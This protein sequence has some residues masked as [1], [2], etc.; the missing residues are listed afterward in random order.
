MGGV[1]RLWCILAAVLLAILALAVADVDARV[2][3]RAFYD[4]LE[5]SP[6]ASQAEIKSA[7]KRLQLS[8]HPDRNPDADPDQIQKVNEAYTVLKDK[9]KRATYDQHGAEG[10]QREDAQEGGQG[11]F[12]PFNPFASFFGGGHQD[13][14]ENKVPSGN[15]VRMSLSVT[16]EQIY[17]GAAITVTRVKG[18]P[19]ETSGTRPCKCRQVRQRIQMAP[20]FFTE[21][22]R[23][24]CEQCPNIKFVPTASQL[25]IELA[26][27]HPEGKEITFFSEGDPHIDGINGDLF[28]RVE[29]VQHDLFT[30]RENDLHMNLTISVTDALVGFEKEFHHLD[31][32]TFKIRRT[33][34]TPPGFIQTIK[35][36]G[37]PVYDI[38][39]MYG[40]LYITYD[41]EFPTG[42]LSTDD[43]QTVQDLFGTGGT[44]K[45]YNGLGK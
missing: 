45:A 18:E 7:Y 5:V 40:D 39:G 9:K 23:D 6:D 34:I 36:E 11:G 17:T 37:L 13:E 42:V 27:G 19:Q 30:R 44:M 22:M 24:E 3:E 10:V 25:E 26:E 15:D 28:F 1:N 16:L 38:L 8:L 43:K 31:N 2:K 20:G 21:A 33:E 35:G 4:A 41:V 14:R 29:S 32:H 12:N